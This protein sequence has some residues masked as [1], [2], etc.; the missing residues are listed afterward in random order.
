MDREIFIN[1]LQTIR[2]KVLLVGGEVHSFEISEPASKEVLSQIEEKYAMQ[3]PPDFAYFL[4]NIAGKVDVSWTISTEE[5]WERCEKLEL[6][7]PV[8]G[9]L[10][11]DINGY[12]DDDIYFYFEN[13]RNFDFL[14]DKLYLSGVDNGDILF[15]NLSAPK[16]QKPIV[17][18]SH[19][20]SCEGFPQLAPSFEA[21]VDA[22]FKLGLVGDDFCEMEPYITEEKGG[23]DPECQAAL[24]WREFFGLI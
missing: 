7:Q 1:A 4:T 23:L 24:E 19:D 15:F 14:N 13:P 6:S 3:F 10:H 11:W 20:A 18:F 9:Y 21:Y 8:C 12:L 5:W 17:Y 2:E 22:L 16:T